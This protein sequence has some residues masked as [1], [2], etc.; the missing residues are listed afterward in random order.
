M[1]TNTKNREEALNGKWSGTGE[2]PAVGDRVD[3]RLSG[4][5]SGEVTGYCVTDGW[6][7]L[8]VKLDA[9]CTA[10]GTSYVGSTRVMVFGVDLA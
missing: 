2:L 9:P 4:F 8:Y 1:T 7:A 3:V 6:T 10:E 5:G